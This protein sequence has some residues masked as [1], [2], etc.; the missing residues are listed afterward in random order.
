MNLF[1]M[2]ALKR[3]AACA[4]ALL[5]AGT[6]GA[7]C[8]EDL[9]EAR[10]AL[11]A[12]TKD[13]DALSARVAVLERELATTR[14]ELARR[15]AAAMPAPAVISQA[16]PAGTSAT[17]PSVVGKA[18]TADRGGRLDPAARPPLGVKAH[19]RPKS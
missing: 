4:Q 11:A 3:A 1:S 17:A 19:E 9:D 15:K 10:S 5:L 7:G 8:K 12:T 14:T 18:S 6:V 2:N 13:R 16:A